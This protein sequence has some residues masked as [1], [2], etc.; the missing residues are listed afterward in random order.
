M[1][2][3]LLFPPAPLAAPCGA[4]LSSAAALERSFRRSMPPVPAYPL[5]PPQAPVRPDLLGQSPRLLSILKV[6]R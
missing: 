6:T 5:P 2:T 4:G 1:T 3:T